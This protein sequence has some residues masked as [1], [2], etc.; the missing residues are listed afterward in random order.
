VFGKMADARK[1]SSPATSA[2][3][4]EALYWAARSWERAG[5]KDKAGAAYRTVLDEKPDGFYAYLA[6]RRA[7]LTARPPIAVSV[8]TPEAPL[9]ETVMKAFTR[10]LELKRA[11]LADFAVAEITLSV[12]SAEPSVQLAILP[13][14]LEIGAYTQALR[15]SLSLY[16]RKLLDENQ[17]YPYIYPRAFES[18]VVPQ[19]TE[20]EI[21]PYFVY[22]LMRQESL[23]N[24]RAVSPAAAYGLMQLLL[25]TARRMATKAGAGEI[26][27]EDLFS[28][29]M[30]V[31]LGTEYLADLGER[32]DNDPVLM[33]AGYNAGEKAAE[34]WR[35]RGKG[36]ELDEFIEKIS[37]RETRAY[38]K[39]VLRN[40]RN[41]LRLYGE[42]GSGT[43]RPA[44]K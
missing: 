32:F 36:L 7:G 42:V 16:R 38:V 24:E 2:G 43:L 1:G 34:R 23:F 14:L 17:L 39:K 27:V 20:R 5:K 18:V 37:Y 9:P 28:P 25:S 29:E 12:E 13:Q 41:Y 22:S 35:E 3:R 33:L 6:E 44:A 19:A 21:D 15:T 31:R 8:Q 40:Y 30:N 4:E 10:A 11:G 26:D